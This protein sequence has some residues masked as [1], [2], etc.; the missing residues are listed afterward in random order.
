MRKGRIAEAP[1]RNL[2][3]T[4]PRSAGR[5]EAASVSSP[6]KGLYEPGSA[7]D[8]HGPVTDDGP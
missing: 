2:R 5:P 6:G 4:C 1:A 3:R 7:F 8:D